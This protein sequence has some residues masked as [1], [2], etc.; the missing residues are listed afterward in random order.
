MNRS[1][2]IIPT[3]R[4]SNKQINALINA[5][6]KCLYRALSRGAHAKALRHLIASIDN[7]LLVAVKINAYFKWLT[8]NAFKVD[9][10]VLSRSK[11]VFLSLRNLQPLQWGPIRA[12][13]CSY[14]VIFVQ[15]IQ[16]LASFIFD[17]HA[18]THL[19]NFYWQSYARVQFTPMNYIKI[20]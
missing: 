3:L 19:V 1:I 10:S 12:I 9:A 16:W 4:F 14:I 15:F 7:N 8:T 5:P 13:K 18:H 2:F 17:Q 6:Y 20:S 11:R